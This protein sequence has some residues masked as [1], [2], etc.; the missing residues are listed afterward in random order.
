MCNS[1]EVFWR[2]TPKTILHHLYYLQYA[3]MKVEQAPRGDEAIK[4]LRGLFNK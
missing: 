1:D 2:L 4:Q 3:K